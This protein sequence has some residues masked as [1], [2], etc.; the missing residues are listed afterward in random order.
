MPHYV[1]ASRVQRNGRNGTDM[2]MREQVSSYSAVAV[3]YKERSW[4][5][6]LL[7]GEARKLRLSIPEKV[8]QLSQRKLFQHKLIALNCVLI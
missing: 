8:V 4:L 2:T 3:G 6:S 5:P 1:E 7:V